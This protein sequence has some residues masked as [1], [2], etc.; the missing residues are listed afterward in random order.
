MLK[1]LLVLYIPFGGQDFVVKATELDSTMS[2]CQR[3][4]NIVVGDPLVKM[5]FDNMLKFKC[6]FIGREVGD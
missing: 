5:K 3:I 2:Q 4:G 6:V 1:V